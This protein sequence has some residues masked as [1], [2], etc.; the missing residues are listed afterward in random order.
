MGREESK[1]DERPS[2]KEEAQALADVIDYL[3]MLDCDGQVRVIRSA[4]AFFA[5]EVAFPRK[6][7]K[8]RTRGPTTRRVFE[9][10]GRTIGE[11]IARV[12]KVGDELRAEVERQT[13]EANDTLRAVAEGR[14]P[15]PFLGDTD[16][17]DTV[18][19]DWCDKRTPTEEIASTW[20]DLV[21]A[22]RLLCRACV[23]DKNGRRVHD[24][25]DP[26]PGDSEGQRTCRACG[27]VRQF[28]DAPEAGCS[29]TM[30]RRTLEVQALPFEST[31]A[32]DDPPRL[33]FGDTPATE[34]VRK[35][36]AD[37]EKR[38]ADLRAKNA[39]EFEEEVARSMPPR[40]TVASATALAQV[41]A[42]PTGI[43]LAPESRE[44]T[45]KA[46]AEARRVLN[47]E[48][49][50]GS[51]FGGGGIPARGEHAEPGDVEDEEAEAIAGSLPSPEDMHGAADGFGGSDEGSHFMSSKQAL[52]N[53]KS[54]DE[55]RRSGL[56]A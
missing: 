50:R 44:T 7:P 38:V 31:V 25:P 4:A 23:V 13:R 52:A 21:A 17:P 45:S 48:I 56:E 33:E 16:E 3:S 43:D 42:R 32:S 9:L 28:G 27:N 11:E 41:A 30:A 5:I 53:E 49:E 51:M 54:D 29:G 20:C 55:L 1:Q 46:I 19:C 34:A 15:H 24:Y 35:A 2:T 39:S 8:L 14:A 47:K 22:N 6:G 10:R 36:F 40:P 26:K 12:L 18:L 37:A